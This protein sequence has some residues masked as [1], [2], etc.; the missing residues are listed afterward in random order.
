MNKNETTL[1]ARTVLARVLKVDLESIGD[2]A[3]Q[4]DFANWDSVQHMNVVLALENEF[5]IEF[6]DAELPGLTTLPLMVASI[7]SHSMA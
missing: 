1:R 5:D 4:V 7:E 3:S 2:N 6:S